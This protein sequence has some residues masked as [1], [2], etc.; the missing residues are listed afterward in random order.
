MSESKPI[1]IIIEELR[2][3]I[4]MACNASKL[5]VA[6]TDMVISDLARQIHIQAVETYQKELTE[7]SNN[8]KEV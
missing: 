5:P 6:I 1:S 4:I 2:Y 7:Y 8:G 3:N